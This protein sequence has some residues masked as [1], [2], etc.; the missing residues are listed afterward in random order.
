ME[1]WGFIMT[2]HVN[3]EMTYNY[4]LECYNCIRKFYGNKKI[5]I[6]DDNSNEQFLN[7]NLIL[8]NLVNCQLIKSEY[9]QA[10][11]LLAYFY[12]HKFQWF[13]YAVIIHDSTFIRKRIEF[14]FHD[15]TFLWHFTHEWDKD[16]EV[17][18]LINE[19]DLFH[20]EHIITL[21]KNKDRWWGWFGIQG[22]ISLSFLK[23]LHEKYNVFSLLS[24]V[25]DRKK[26]CCLERLLSV[27]VTLEIPYL[28]TRK[29]LLGNIHLYERWG[30]RFQE[31]RRDKEKQQLRDLPII[32]VWSGR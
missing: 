20:K 30:Y 3:S 7:D 14:H 4:F 13:R 8:P 31:Y 32:K 6:I 15:I 25:R 21:Y 22:I 10:G 29:S 2:R 27:I 19:S 9:P 23:R 12:L 28:F 24:C 1:E 16:D 17:L 11:E 26:R 18:N 5:I